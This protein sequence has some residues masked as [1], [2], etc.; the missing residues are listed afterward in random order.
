MSEESKLVCATCGRE[1][2]KKFF[3]LRKSPALCRSCHYQRLEVRE[4]EKARM[5]EYHQR[6]EVKERRK[7]SMKE[8]NQR[9]EARVREKARMKEH[10]QLP[11][12][13]ARMKEHNQR[14]EIKARMK[15]YNQ[16][17]EIKERA[18]EYDQRPEVKERKRATANAN[19]QQATDQYIKSLIHNE[20]KKILKAPDIPQN[21]IELKRHALI[22]KRAITEQQN[23]QHSTTDV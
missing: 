9:L 20:S 11:D 7:A 6:P 3:A 16:R 21:I 12:I 8:Y 2:P 22:L 19:I 14:P 10:N 17:P 18:K 5:K 23:E 13:K 1:R 15:E 4:R